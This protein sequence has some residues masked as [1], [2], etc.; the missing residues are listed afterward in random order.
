[1]DSVI[2][3]WCSKQFSKKRFTYLVFCS[4]FPSKIEVKAFVQ[5]AMQCLVCFDIGTELRM[6][7]YPYSLL[8]IFF[9]WSTTAKTR[10]G[11]LRH[12]IRRVTR[13]SRLRML[14]STW[15]RSLTS[16]ASDDDDAD[17]YTKTCTIPQ[18]IMKSEENEACFMPITCIIPEGASE[19][20]T[21]N[22]YT[23]D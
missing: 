11:I 19:T 22:V 13:E 10:P 14:D 2:A 18:V 7:A 12:S 6:L 21:S 23:L 16:N 17:E 20:F 4:I 5:D 8:R 1:M 3:I 15:R 9:F